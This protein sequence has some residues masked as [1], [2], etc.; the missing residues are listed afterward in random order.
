MAV[1]SY[2][3]ARLES[4]YKA[5]A[6]SMACAVF[7]IF[8]FCAS[9]GL[10]HGKLQI[11]R[12]EDFPPLTLAFYDRGA[13]PERFHGHEA[14]FIGLLFADAPQKIRT[15]KICRLQITHIPQG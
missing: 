1:S 4:G 12:D 11:P 3:S 14:K 5:R 2:R 15:L 7:S 8:A 6:S 10:H 13:A 9:V